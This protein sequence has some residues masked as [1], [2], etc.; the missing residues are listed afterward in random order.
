MG[1]FKQLDGLLE[2][3]DVDAVAGSK[4]KRFHFRIPTPGLM[5]EMDTGF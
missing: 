3:N 2:I 5:P 1:D 4:N